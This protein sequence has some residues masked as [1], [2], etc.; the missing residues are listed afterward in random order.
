MA[1]VIDK[2]DIPRLLEALSGYERYGPVEE[3]GVLRYKRLDG[4]APVLDIT[5]SPKPPKEVFFP[6]TEVMFQFE[7]DGRKFTGMKAPELGTD[8]ILLFG[9][10]P[11]DSS[12]ISILDK[13]FAWDYDD[14]YY[15]NRRER[16]TIVG[17]ACTQPNMPLST[18]FCTSV[19]GH[20]AGEDGLDVLLTDI[21]GKYLVESYTEKGNRVLE[22]GGGVFAEA[23]AQAVQAAE[24]AKKKADEGITRKF[25]SEGMDAVLE[26]TF[27]KTYWDQFSKRCLGCGICTY[28]CPTC[29]CFDIS[30]IIDIRGGRRERTWDSCQNTYYTIHASGH[31]PRPGKKERQRNRIYHKYMYSRKNLDVDGCVGCGRCIAQCPVDIDIV[32]VCEGARKEAGEGGGGQ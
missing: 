19:C 26:K 17:L 27:E 24:N 1:K 25:D 9:I 32:E 18:C 5:N 8:P 12:A 30:D 28:L 15:L 7:R 11:C 3:D 20:P 22:L 16:A 10:R 31:D 21:G 14:P 29:H 4:K 23:D 6:Q 13:L 2:N